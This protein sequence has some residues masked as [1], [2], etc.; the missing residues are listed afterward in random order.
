[1]KNAEVFIKT[2]LSDN[3]EVIVQCS[4]HLKYSMVRSG[5]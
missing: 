1:M 5:V 4:N 3:N 2:G